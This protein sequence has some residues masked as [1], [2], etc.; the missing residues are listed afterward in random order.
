MSLP[1][2][3]SHSIGIEETFMECGFLPH[4]P[5]AARIRVVRGD[6]GTAT[7]RRD[8]RDALTAIRASRS[9]IANR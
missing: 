7:M 1:S 3:G 8:P 2:S 4:L 6:A 5:R 9:F